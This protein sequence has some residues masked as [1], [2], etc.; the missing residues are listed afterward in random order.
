LFPGEGGIDVRGILAALPLGIPYP[1]KFPALRSGAMGVEECARLAIRAAQEYLEM[2]GK[3][4]FRAP[5][6]DPK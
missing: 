1:W 2:G 4:M 6:D 3:G 5:R